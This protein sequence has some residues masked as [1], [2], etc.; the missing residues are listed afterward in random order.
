MYNLYSHILY[1]KI[2]NH[3]H[4]LH[5]QVIQVIHVYIYIYIIIHPT[6]GLRAR[7]SFHLSSGWSQVAKSWP[8]ISEMKACRL[9]SC[10]VAS[11]GIVM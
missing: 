11:A 7:L 2:S 1:K 6:Q 9:K 10:H 4:I 8:S 3:I 5:V